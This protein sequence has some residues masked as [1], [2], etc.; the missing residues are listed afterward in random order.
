MGNPTGVTDAD[1]QETFTYD[2]VNRVETALTSGTS[3][4]QPQVL[5]T[6][7]YDAVGDRTQLQEDGGTST[8][9]SSNDPKGQGLMAL[10]EFLLRPTLE[11]F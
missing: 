9:K 1:S 8:M 6:S 4:L 11:L 3:G 10:C 2:G 5:L 7:V